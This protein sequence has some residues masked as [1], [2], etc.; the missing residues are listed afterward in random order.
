MS[1]TYSSQFIVIM[2]V[3]VVII[4]FPNVFLL[5]FSFDIFFFEFNI[6]LFFVEAAN[7]NLDLFNGCVFPQTEPDLQQFLEGS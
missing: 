5:D 3:S 4:S 7:I 2:G 1:M 6:L